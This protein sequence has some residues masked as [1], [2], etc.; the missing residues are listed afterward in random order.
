MALST[1]GTNAI[2]DATIATGDIADGAVTAAK[3]TANTVYDTWYLSS[4]VTGGTTTITSNWAQWG[5]GGYAR[6][7]SVMSQSSGVF[8]F[9]STGI[10][11]I[12]WQAEFR[13]NGESRYNEVK[14]Q[15]T[16]DNSSY[17]DRAYGYASINADTGTGIANGRTST[18]IDVT[19]ISNVKVK[20]GASCENSSATLYHSSSNF[21][22][23]RAIFI[24]LGDT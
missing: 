1:I 2:T 9:P 14:I 19:D 22:Q 21:L 3:S 18:F 20:F 7:S 6:S 11:Y 16:T 13:F 24:K 15:V 10:Y 4:S 12:D 8:S 5:G 23:T 17:N